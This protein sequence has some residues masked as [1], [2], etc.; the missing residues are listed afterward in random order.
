MKFQV[1]FKTPDAPE[2]AIQKEYEYISCGA[3]ECGENGSPGTCLDC[4]RLHDQA[5]DTEADM[6]AVINKFVEYNEQVT[7]EFDT[8]TGEARVVPVSKK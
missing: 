6:W 5:R 4:E 3:P 2:T 1:L 7:I 8:E